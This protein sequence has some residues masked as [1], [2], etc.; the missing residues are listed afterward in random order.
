ML[1]TK[2]VHIE[3]VGEDDDLE[4]SW[5]SWST[6]VVKKKKKKKGM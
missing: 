4:V 6:T 3:Y 2:G 1:S 5:Q